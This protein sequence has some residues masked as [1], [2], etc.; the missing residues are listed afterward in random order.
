[1]NP[2]GKK[3]MGEEEKAGTS[4]VQTVQREDAS[5]GLV[6]KADTLSYMEI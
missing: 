2:Q 4:P 6:V 3:M 1:M 5:R